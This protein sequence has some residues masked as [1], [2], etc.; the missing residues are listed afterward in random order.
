MQPI[1]NVAFSDLGVSLSKSTHFH[2]CQQ[3][4]TKA[5]NG[6]ISFNHSVY[7]IKQ[8]TVGH[9]AHNREK[10]RNQANKHVKRDRFV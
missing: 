3:S 9:Q 4:V 8:K 6:V 2:S 10:R 5:L 1:L 7:I